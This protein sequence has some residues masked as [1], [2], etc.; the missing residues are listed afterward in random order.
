MSLD[1]TCNYCGRQWELEVK[2]W[3]KSYDIKCDRC[4][5]KDVKTKELKK[6]TGDVFGYRFSPPFEEKKKR[7]KGNDEVEYFN[8]DSY[9]GVGS[10]GAD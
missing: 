10:S 9:W 6:E 2:P 3:M 8:S 5:D 1:C 4:G 7:D